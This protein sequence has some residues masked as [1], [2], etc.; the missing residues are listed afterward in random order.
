M[1]LNEIKDDKFRLNFDNKN[2]LSM[3]KSNNL[4]RLCEDK[5]I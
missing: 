2:P 5:S 4:F 1:V 3:A